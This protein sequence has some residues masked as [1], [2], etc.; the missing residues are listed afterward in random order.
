[1][2]LKTIFKFRSSTAPL[3]RARSPEPPTLAAS[4]LAVDRGSEV[5]EHQ[6]N[7]HAGHRNVHPNGPGPA[8]DG[9]VRI[10][11]LSQ[12]AA[13]RDQGERNDK[14]RKEYVGSRHDIIH[15]SNP[16]LAAKY[17]YG[18]EKVIREIANQENGRGGEGGKHA[19]VMS[20]DILAPDEHKAGR[21]KNRAQ[22]VERG[23]DGGE[24]GYGHADVR[25]R[26]AA[27][28]ISRVADISRP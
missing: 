13:Q 19:A 23:V 4:W 5:I 20:G 17:C 26:S 10:E 3:E 25:S 24:I 7:E 22:A 12:G 2:I 28:V 15:W 27:A 1:M 6:V 9:A 11:A 16:T 8:S 14:R 18:M 21:Q